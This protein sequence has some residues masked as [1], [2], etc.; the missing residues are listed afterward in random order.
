[1]QLVKKNP[2]KSRVRVTEIFFKMAGWGSIGAMAQPIHEINTP[3]D[4]SHW[5][6]LIDVSTTRQLFVYFFSEKKS[7][8]KSFNKIDSQDLKKWYRKSILTSQLFSHWSY[9]YNDIFIVFQLKAIGPQDP[10]MQLAKKKIPG[11]GFFSEPRWDFGNEFFF[12]DHSQTPQCL[13]ITP[14]LIQILTQLIKSCSTMS[15]LA[16][17]LF[18]SADHWLTDL[19]KI[20]RFDLLFSTSIIKTKKE[21]LIQLDMLSVIEITNF[22]DAI[23]L[24]SQSKITIFIKNKSP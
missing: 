15:L 24:I 10:V 9:E 21:S 3:F 7:H 22:D 12:Q 14:I 16:T 20:L 6:Y 2:Q 23:Q 11:L 19:N 4:R 13:R 17:S 5:V 1:M 18:I 8:P